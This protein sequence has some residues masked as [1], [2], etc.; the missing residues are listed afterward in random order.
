MAASCRSLASLFGT[1]ERCGCFCPRFERTYEGHRLLWWWQC[2]GVWF[3]SQQAL[4]MGH[5]FFHL[6]RV[7]TWQQEYIKR[8][9]HLFSVCHLSTDSQFEII[10]PG[11]ARWGRLFCRGSERRLW[12]GRRFSILGRFS[13]RKAK[14]VSSCCKRK[15]TAVGTKTPIAHQA[16]VSGKSCQTQRCRSSVGQT[17]THSFLRLWFRSLR[18]APWPTKR[19]RRWRA[20]SRLISHH[21][22]RSALRGVWPWLFPVLLANPTFPSRG[23]SSRLIHCDA[24]TWRSSQQRASLNPGWWFELGSRSFRS[25]HTNCLY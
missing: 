22:S 12:R 2:R 15:C 10:P 5:V 1:K 6:F 20:C 13:T 9:V 21:Q 16:R 23:G 4:W 7:K 3:A 11:N 8:S 18:R 17:A 14:T 19:W 25:Q 24:S